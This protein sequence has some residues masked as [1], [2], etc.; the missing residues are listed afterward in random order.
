MRIAAIPG[1]LAC[2][3]I[4]LVPGDAA[5]QEPKPSG[6]VLKVSPKSLKLEVGKQARLRAGLVDKSGKAVGTAFAHR[7]HLKAGAT[8]KFKAV[9]FAPEG[10]SRID[11]GEVIVAEAWRKNRGSPWRGTPTLPCAGGSDSHRG[12]NAD[13]SRGWT[14]L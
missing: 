6:P 12:P 5:S 3:A 4:L 1:V 2:L 13:S 14:I 10:F 9:S 11:R 7:E 8:W